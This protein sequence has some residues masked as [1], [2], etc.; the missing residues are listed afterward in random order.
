KS[1]EV[2]ATVRIVTD[3]PGP[4]HRHLKSV[5]VTGFCDLVGIVE[6]V[7]YIL[8]NCTVLERMVVDPV[9]IWMYCGYPYTGHF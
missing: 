3:L 8:R 1:D 7:L 6:L 5:H 9:M 4:L 2:P